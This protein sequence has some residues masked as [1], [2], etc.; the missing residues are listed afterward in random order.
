MK[1]PPNSDTPTLGELYPGLSAD[2]LAEAEENLDRY[3]AVVVR[4]QDRI[5]SESAADARIR[6]LTGSPPKP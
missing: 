5:W 3:I 4:I 2:E 1:N 6:G